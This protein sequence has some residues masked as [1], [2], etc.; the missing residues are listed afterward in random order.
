MKDL[1]KSRLAKMTAIMLIMALTLTGCTSG[2]DSQ[3]TNNGGKQVET[4]KKDNGSEQSENIQVVEWKELTDVGNYVDTDTTVPENAIEVSTS[5]EFKKALS[6]VKPGETILLHEGTYLGH[7]KCS[8]SGNENAYI[9]I[10]SY[11]GE[12]ATL[13]FPKDSD[14]GAIQ[15]EGQKYINIKN[16]KFSDLQSEEA[17]GV[18][19][20]GGEAY[21]SIINCEFEKIVTSVPGTDDEAGG[22]G[23]AI[24]LFGETK[25]PISHINIENN[26]VHDNV[27]GWAENISIAANCEY[28]YVRNNLVK[29]CSNIGIDFYG[30]A[31]YCRYKELDQA[32]HCECTGNVVANCNS[33]Y[34]SNAGIYVDGSYDIL[35]ENNESYGNFYGI[36]IGSEEW[37]D[38]YTDEKRVHNVTVK[39][40]Y[41]HDNIECGMRVGGWTNDEETG[42][43]YDCLIAANHFKNN[44]N[45]IILA[46]CDKI[47]FIKNQFEG[48]MKTEEAIVYDEEISRKKITNI[49]CED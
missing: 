45:E 21:V 13:T 30:N 42:I 12:Q 25:E 24:I 44:A 32:R 27:N 43:V 35:I 36:E 23:N 49:I 1:S 7:F 6:N 11:P 31:E 5:D 29:D 15:L 28:V 14:G 2:N 18:L 17:Y 4:G 38:Y 22:S 33:F 47:R 48:G 46:K 10:K 3:K 37:R 26:Y 16:L 34:A 41:V 9:T 8:V 20:T 19:M 40:N 39:N